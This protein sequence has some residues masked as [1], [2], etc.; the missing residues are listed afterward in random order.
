M[1]NTFVDAQAIPKPTFKLVIKMSFVR[2]LQGV[3]LGFFFCHKGAE[4]IQRSWQKVVSL[5]T[6]PAD[7]EPHWKFW[8]RVLHP[9]VTLFLALQ[10]PPT[11]EEKILVVAPTYLAFFSS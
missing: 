3:Y 10:T 11:P 6:N 8:N 2:I 5:P 9:K 1:E 4:Q 7:M